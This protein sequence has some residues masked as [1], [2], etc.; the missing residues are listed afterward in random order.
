MKNNPV[1]LVVDDHP[2]NIDLLE[3]H[4]VPQGYEIVMAGNG[5]EALL[6]LSG[7]QI[8]LILLDVQMPGIDGF[9]VTR[10]IRKNP[11]YTQLPVILVTALRETEERVKGIDAGC[12]DFIS[13]PFDKL[14]L[15]TRIRSLLKIKAYNDLRSNYQKKLESE[16]ALRTMELKH[17]LERVKESSLETIY[18]LS[19]ASEYKDE[20][21]G[22]HVKR[23]SHY[24]A[25]VA[26]SLGFS[27]TIVETIRYAAP[28]HDVGKIGIPD[29]ILLKPGKLDSEEWIIMKQH[30]VIGASILKDSGAEIIKMGEIIA[31]GHHEKWDGSGYPNKLTGIEIPVVCRICAI[32]DVFDALTSKRP[33]KEAFSVEKS[34]AIIREGKGSHFDP[35]VADAFFSVQDE[36]VTIMNKYKDKNPYRLSI[37]EKEELVLA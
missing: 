6:K 18:R 34:L 9:E 10:R 13:K 26:A 21:T 4:L 20:D 19:T 32:A 30:T 33:Y 22:A 16:V 5:E 23:M 1:I 11:A 24:S 37:V 3:A 28:M 7:N 17:A 36:I 31:L 12:D 29:R 25:A 15:L 2:E 8:D 35:D 27:G 14:E